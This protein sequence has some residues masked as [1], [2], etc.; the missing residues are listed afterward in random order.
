MPPAT[1]DFGED[2]PPDLQHTVLSVDDP[3][4]SY[5]RKPPSAPRR[6]AISLPPGDPWYDDGGYISGDG[7][8]YGGEQDDHFLGSGVSNRQEWTDASAQEAEAS[9]SLAGAK[10]R[11]TKNNNRSEVSNAFYP[12]RNR[13]L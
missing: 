7:G 10:P 9:T 12:A 11:N 6:E 2:A 8:G 3:S 5:S 13:A 1:I 4:A